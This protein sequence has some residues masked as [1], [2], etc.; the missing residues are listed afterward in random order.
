[1]FNFSRIST[2]IKKNEGFRSTVYL[3]QLGNPTIGY[4]HLINLKDVFFVRKKYSK[5]FLL[6]VFDN[7]LRKAILDFKKNYHYK[8]LPDNVQE[9]IIEMIFQLGIRNILQFKKFNLCIKNNNFYLA[10]LEMIN[11]LWYQHT[12][13]RVDRLI[14]ILLKYNVRK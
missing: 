8:N 7:D 14:N 6:K 1:M 12:P 4:G 10:A 13:K 5:R 2:R 11:S 3:D 9:V